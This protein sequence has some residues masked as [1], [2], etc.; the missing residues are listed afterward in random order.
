MDALLD[1]HSARTEIKSVFIQNFT[2]PE[3]DF[4][5]LVEMAPGTFSISTNGTG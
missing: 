1:E 4:G 3:A 2:S 5:E